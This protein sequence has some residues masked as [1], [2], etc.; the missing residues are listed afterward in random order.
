MDA[1]VLL[2]DGDCG[3]CRW[4]ADKLLVW[5]RGRPLRAVALQSHE[6]DDLLGP[7]DDLAKM[8]SW[9][10]VDRRGLAYSASAAVAP[11]MRELPLGWPAAT[12]A[13]AFPGL[14]DRSY[15]WLSRNRFRF[16]RMLGERACAVD[17]AGAAAAK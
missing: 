16:G 15:R 5:G 12:A 8:G 14:T 1:A 2:F 13:S 11:L 9:H 4:A 7:M 10:F 17:P 3:F 6:A